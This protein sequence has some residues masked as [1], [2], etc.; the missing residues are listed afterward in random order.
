LGS[1]T[2]V[3]AGASISGDFGRFGVVSPL[4]KNPVSTVFGFEYRFENDQTHPDQVLQTG[5]LVGGGGATPPV[6]GSFDDMD[7]Y[8]EL[9]VP[10]IED[11]PFAKAVDLDLGLRHSGYSIYGTDD[12]FDTNTYKIQGDWQIVDDVKLRGGYNRAVRAPNIFE[13]FNA[14]TVAIAGNGDPCAGPNPSATLAACERTGVTPAQF[15]NI[16]DCIDGQCSALTEGNK[17]LQPEKADTYTWGIVYTPTYLKNFTFSMDYF[18]IDI[19][20]AIGVVPFT[21]SLNACLAGPTVLCN[22]I[23][24]GPGGI[25]FGQTGFITEQEINTGSNDTSGIDFAATYKHDLDFLGAGDLGSVLFNFTGTWT[26]ALTTTPLSGGGSFDCAGLFGTTC[27][28]PTPTWRHQVRATWVTP[29]DA[30]LSVDWRHLSSV[31]FDGNSSNPLLN[32]GFVD[33]LTQNISS[34]DYFDLSGTWQVTHNIQ[35]R[36]GV[37]NIFDRDPPLVDSLV[38]AGSNGNTYPGTYDDLGRE[39][40]MGINVKF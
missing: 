33:T 13:L 28:S 14:P 36:A 25:L 39:I 8:G 27:G 4:A 24:R 7:F 9:H 38:A 11:L 40:F 35:L 3:V 32:Q 21:T 1:E 16:S 31:S 6:S 5:D 30:D 26:A 15:G 10:V 34:F 29:W 20:D 23:H 37:N 19:A 12:T 2:E 17:A 22:N 18:T